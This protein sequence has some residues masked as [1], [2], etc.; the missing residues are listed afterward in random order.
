M[1]LAA[2]SDDF[3]LYDI[4][5]VENIF[6]LEYMP[7]APGDYVRVYLYGLMMCRYPTKEESIEDVGRRLGMEPE[8]VLKAMRYWE[9]KGLLV[10]ISDVPPTFQYRNVRSAILD[11]R[12]DDNPA[13]R[14]RAFNSRAEDILGHLESRHYQMLMEWVEDL[15]LPEEVVLL[16]VEKTNDMLTLRNGGKQRSLAYVFKTL[17][18]RALDWAEREINTPE[19]ARTELQKDLPPYLAAC[20][21]LRSLNLR[22]A[23]TMAEIA[24]CE[25][26]MGEWSFTEEDILSVLPETVKSARPSFAYLDGILASRHGR[27]GQEDLGAAVNQVLKA[28]GSLSTTPTES[29]TDAYAGFLSQ[30]FAPDAVLRAA[31]LCN[32]RGRGT[33]EKLG[34][35]LAK[36]LDLGL[37]TT[38]AIDE[39]LARRQ[40][41]RRIALKLWD[42]AGIPGEVSEAALDQ[43][44]EWL[45]MAPIEV[46]EY[47][48]ECA[49]GLKLPDRSITKRLKECREAG[50]RTVEGAKALRSRGKKS[51]PAPAPRGRTLDD[52]YFAGIAKDLDLPEEGEAP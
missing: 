34:D 29:L 41:L 10:G 36:W 12:Q 50:V 1:A 8:Q 28:L 37:T 24:L 47:A 15:R 14:H 32:S 11:Q 5:P 49:R 40:D 43:V 39:Y 13:Y 17:K 16:M 18:E 31:V 22:R 42:K 51:A 9:K 52:Q 6:L 19:K 38:Q 4:T 23:P 25:K 44:Q 45:G 7:S 48:A 33:F 21:V 20:K 26:W 30:G 27:A 35:V 2:L 3:A 46:I